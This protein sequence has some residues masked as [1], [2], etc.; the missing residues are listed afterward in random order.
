MIVQH[1]TMN[2]LHASSINTLRIMTYHKKPIGAVL[3]IGVGESNI[4][5]ASSGGIYAQV[6]LKA[7]I[8]TSHALN[9]AGNTVIRHPDTKV[10]IPGFEIPMWHECLQFVRKCAESI[11]GVPLVGWDI[12]V[13]PKGPVLVEV[14]ER[15]DP[16]LIQSISRAG[17]KNSLNGE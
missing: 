17:I 1:E 7:G 11:E 6:D 9:Y 12:A 2:K 16:F 10:I 15:P 5:N 3:R 4:D 13:G 8:V 14:N